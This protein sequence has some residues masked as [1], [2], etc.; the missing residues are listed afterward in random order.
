MRDPDYKGNGT[1]AW[2][3]DISNP[4]TAGQTATLSS[5]LVT[6]PFHPAWNHWAISVIHL[7]EIEGT[8]PANK[9]YPEAEYEF[10][11]VSLNPDHQPDPDNPTETFHYLT[12]IDVVEH[13]HGLNDVQAEELCELCV[14]AIVDGRASPDQDWRPWWKACIKNTVEH[15]RTGSCPGCGKP[16]CR[17][18]H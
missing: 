2:R 3:V 9:Q 12:P 13:F 16:A 6:G 7:R 15:I 18:L 1:A 11:I 10:L 5:W 8:K 17:T 14:R 4:M